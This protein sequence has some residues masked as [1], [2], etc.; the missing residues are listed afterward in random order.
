VKSASR[1][2]LIEF[3]GSGWFPYAWLY[4]AIAFTLLIGFYHGLVERHSRARIVLGSL[5]MFAG[6]LVVFRTV[7]DQ[8]ST[9]SALALHQRVCKTSVPRANKGCVWSWFAQL[10]DGANTPANVNAAGSAATA[11]VNLAASADG[12]IGCD[13]SKKSRWLCWLEADVQISGG[14]SMSFKVILAMGVI[15]SSR[16]V[17]ENCTRAG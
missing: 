3:G 6:L 11:P 1:S 8:H 4:S 16:L 7:L 17:V 15:F 2:L 10:V 14:T 12:D 9:L 5:L 13:A